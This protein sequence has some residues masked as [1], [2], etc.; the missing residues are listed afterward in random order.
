MFQVISF[1]KYIIAGLLII[2]LCSFLMAIYVNYFSN[3]ID[4]TNSYTPDK[5]IITYINLTQVDY[6]CWSDSAT[7]SVVQIPCIL[8]LVNTTVKTDLIFYRNIEEKK[9]NKKYQT[10]VYNKSRLIKIIKIIENYIF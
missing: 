5:C 10:Q 8:V 4:N 2:A 1:A 6:D 3:A 9:M 7:V